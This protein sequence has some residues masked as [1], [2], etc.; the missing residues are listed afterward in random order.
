MYRLNVEKFVE[1]SQQELVGLLRKEQGIIAVYPNKD[2]LVVSYTNGCYFKL[3]ELCHISVYYGEYHEGGYYDD[4]Q[5]DH[6]FMSCQTEYFGV[7][8]PELAIA[9]FVSRLNNIGSKATNTGRSLEQIHQQ[10]IK[11]KE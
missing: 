4:D 8:E 7:N 1:L 2:E 10:Q 9:A 5:V 6:H 3:G 11:I